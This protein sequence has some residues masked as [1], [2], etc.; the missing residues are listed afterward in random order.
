[1][2]QEYFYGVELPFF[3]WAANSNLKKH[4]LFQPNQE[5]S[6]FYFKRQKETKQSKKPENYPQSGTET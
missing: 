2:F 6:Y 3:T 1:M 4:L 5:N